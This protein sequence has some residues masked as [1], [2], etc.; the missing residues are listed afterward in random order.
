[1]LSSTL[2]LKPIKTI[3]LEW[4]FKIWAKITII[5]WLKY[6]VMMKIYK[7]D[8]SICRSN[9]PITYFSIFVFKSIFMVSHYDISFYVYV[10]TLSWKSS[11]AFVA[12][13]FLICSLRSF[14]LLSPFFF[15]F[16]QAIAFIKPNLYL[17]ISLHYL[18]RRGSDVK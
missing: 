18:L 11:W 13:E 7:V 1:M 6:F 9:L 3:F 14:N 12:N 2:E 17:H 10:P 15:V 16:P 5:R 4:F 8:L